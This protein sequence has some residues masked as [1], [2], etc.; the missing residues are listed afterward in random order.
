MI[1]FLT[2]LGHPELKPRDGNCCAE[3]SAFCQQNLPIAG[4]LT[5]FT[6][7]LLWGLPKQ[8]TALV[9]R[10]GYSQGHTFLNRFQAIRLSSEMQ[11]CSNTPH[12]VR[13]PAIFVSGASAMIRNALI[14]IAFVSDFFGPRS[15]YQ[16]S[17][18]ISSCWKRLIPRR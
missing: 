9:P 10:A 5:L 11:S 12:A 15:D 16:H 17:H 3:V 8:A 4:S 13:G 1:C 2:A 6:Y 18:S 7:F 14:P